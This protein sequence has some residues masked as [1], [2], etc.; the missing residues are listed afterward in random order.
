[1][2]SCLRLWSSC[3]FPPLPTKAGR[4]VWAHSRLSPRGRGGLVLSD[5]AGL[6]STETGGG[7]AQGSSR[8][9][10]RTPPGP[11]VFCHVCGFVA[12][13]SRYLSGA[14]DQEEKLPDDLRLGASGLT[15]RK[16][17]FLEQACPGSGPRPSCPPGSA[18]CAPRQTPQS[19]SRA[20]LHS[21]TGERTFKA[22]AE[23]GW[24]RKI[25]AVGA[26]RSHLH[27]SWKL[28]ANVWVLP[29]SGQHP[30]GVAPSENPNSTGDRSRPSAVAPGSRPPREDV[31]SP[32]RW[33]PHTG[34]SLCQRLA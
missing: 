14:K 23:R 26:S 22:S 21:Y 8:S 32:A 33:W 25:K 34:E 11:A 27:W 5:G 6:F 4:G 9:P 10:E 31:V 12:S 24:G 28:M 16:A 30:Q 18:C 3:C 15:R 7:E 2:I 29:A 13:R 1:M 17:T 20:S 19:G